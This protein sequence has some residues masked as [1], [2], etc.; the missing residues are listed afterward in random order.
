M[1]DKHRNL[2]D[3]LE[4]E[5]QD[6]YSA[7]TQLIEALPKMAKKANSEKLKQAIEDHLEETKEQAKRLEQVMEIMDIG[8]G[9]SKCKAMAGLVTE[10]EE[11]LEED[12]SKEV[13]DAGII[14]IA[15]KV[16]HYEISGYGSASHFAE[17]LGHSEV[18]EL[19]EQT[20]EEEKAADDK[21][22]DIAKSEVN[23]RA[24]S[25]SAK[26]TSRSNGSM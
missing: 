18:Q 7:E 21:L 9:Q 6:L 25:D 10:G 4:H 11:W 17:M 5:V 20:L 23:R 3:L 19:L 16:E 8:P 13:K 24:L 1:S 14:A 26:E 15:Q 2:Q 12:A 22:N